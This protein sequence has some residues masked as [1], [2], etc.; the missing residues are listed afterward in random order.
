MNFFNW[1]FKRKGKKE[2]ISKDELKKEALGSIETEEAE[3]AAVIA[4]AI[5]SIEDSDNEDNMIAAIAAA[6][7]EMANYADMY[8]TAAIAA[9]IITSME[10]D[11]KEAV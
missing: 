9:S 1:L 3:I 10:E 8:E 11:L 5:A 6:L 4:A 7:H 2:T